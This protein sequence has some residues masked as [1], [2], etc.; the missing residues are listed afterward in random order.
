MK[1]GCGEPFISVKNRKARPEF[2]RNHVDKAESFWDKVLWTDETKINM[3]Q[4]DGNATVWR[5]KGKAD[6]PKYTSATVKHGGGNVMAWACMS[7]DK[8]MCYCLSHFYQ[9]CCC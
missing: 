3:F 4:S 8:S 6:D 1:Q 5:P 7:G 2:A 9:C